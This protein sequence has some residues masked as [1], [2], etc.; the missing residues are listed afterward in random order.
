RPGASAGHRRRVVAAIRQI[1]SLATGVDMRRL[2]TSTFLAML[3]TALAASP[4]LSADIA[5]ADAARAAFA[6]FIEIEGRQPPSVTGTIEAE[7]AAIDARK[8]WQ[9]K[10]AEADASF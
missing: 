4:S 10:R 8:E 2:L 3:A 1:D 5:G 7:R 9:K 6:A